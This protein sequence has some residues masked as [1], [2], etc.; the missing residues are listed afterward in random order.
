MTYCEN[1]QR[2]RRCE[3]QKRNRFYERKRTKINKKINKLNIE[4][5]YK[6]TNK[7]TDR[8]KHVITC[9]E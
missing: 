9:T 2:D 8:Q 6:Q 7:Q 3:Y 1:E 5:K 4:A